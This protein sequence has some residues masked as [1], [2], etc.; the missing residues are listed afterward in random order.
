MVH[1]PLY[2]HA[3]WIP[4]YTILLSK[5]QYT[6]STFLGVIKS[7]VPMGQMTA[8]FNL[9][10][11]P[12]GIYNMVPFWGVTIKVSKLII[13]WCR[14]NLPWF[15][16]PPNVGEMRD[17]I[18]KYSFLELNYLRILFKPYVVNTYKIIRTN[19]CKVNPCKVKSNICCNQY[20]IIHYYKNWTIL[21]WG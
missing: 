14:T 21:D 16:L 3:S 1:L 11:R 12:H 10:I 13:H 2:I 6:Y 15:F 4:W 17:P 20:V 7:L 8:L 19:F 9:E 5:V 18:L